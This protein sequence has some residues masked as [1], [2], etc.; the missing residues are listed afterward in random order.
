MLSTMKKIIVWLF[1]MLCVGCTHQPSAPAVHINLVNNNRSIRFTGLDY[2]IISEIN[3]DAI[4]GIWQS[5]IPVYRMP[6][7]TDLKNYQPAQPG[8]YQIIDSAVV[9]TPDTAFI[10]GK[11]Y[12]MRYYEFGEGKS[13]MDYFEHHIKLGGTKYIDLIFKRDSE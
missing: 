3:R 12:F 13:V 6:A 8:V 9:F 5:L 10:K 11:A 4:P 1:P 2:A 7:D